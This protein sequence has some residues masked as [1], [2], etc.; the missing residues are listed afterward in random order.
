MI[1]DRPGRIV[2][3]C[4]SDRTDEDVLN[5]FCR[6][7]DYKPVTFI[8]RQNVSGERMPIYHTNVMMCLAEDFAVIC[9]DSIDDL[10]ER[11]M[12]LSAI[13]N[14]VNEIIEISEN[15]LNSFA[16]NM[17][18][19]KNRKGQ[20]FLVMSESA[21]KSLEKDQI[22]IIEKYCPI[23]HSPLD[24]IETCGGGSARCM[25]AEIFLPEKS[26]TTFSD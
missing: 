18:Q 2:F 3:A 14:S 8:A 26:K 4:L 17:L 6:V 5:E 1:L 22:E 11:K 20:K 24:T 19:V 25:M 21:Y 12:V 13:K 23:I 16:G 10:T 9:S 7:F 15:Q